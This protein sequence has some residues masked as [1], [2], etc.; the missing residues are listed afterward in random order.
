MVRG[1]EVETDDV[2]DFLD[3]ERVVG[4]FEMPLAMRLDAEQ[5][6]PALDRAFR[7]AGV[8]RHRTDAPVRA[9]W[10]FG[11]QSRVDHFRNPFI[12]VRAGTA[13]T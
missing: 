8:L 5:V 7:Y 10:W 3:E 6:E 2:M 4:D 12:S 13:G 1:I 11:L 9:V